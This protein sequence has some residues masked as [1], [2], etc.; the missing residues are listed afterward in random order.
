MYIKYV[1]HDPI[2]N[3]EQQIINFDPEYLQKAMDSG[4][5][6]IGVDENN[7][8]KIIKKLEEVVKP[9]NTVISGVPVVLPSYVDSRIEELAGVIETLVDSMVEKS[10]IDTRISNSILNKV[11]DIRITAQKSLEAEE[12]MLANRSAKIGAQ[13][14]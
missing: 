9:A 12:K 6:I 8:R 11:T 7:K 10:Q 4:M 14:M 3:N 2:G 5:I 13:N 1:L